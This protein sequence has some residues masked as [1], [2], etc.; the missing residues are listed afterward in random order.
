MNTSGTGYALLSNVS[1]GLKY[2]FHLFNVSGLSSIELHVGPQ[3]EH[4]DVA[5]I[6]YKAAF[7]NLTQVSQGRVAA[8]TLTED[9]MLG[10]FLLPLGD[11]LATSFVYSR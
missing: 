3:S 7:A 5:A 10:P 8:G 4:G 11:H 9:D 1:E 6:F 2:E